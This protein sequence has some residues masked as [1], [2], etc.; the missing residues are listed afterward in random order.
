MNTTQ[1][2][3]LQTL[4]CV[5]SL[6][7]LSACGQAT[8]AAPTLTPIPSATQ[9]SAPTNT[10]TPTPPPTATNTPE[11]TPIPGVQVY[12]VSSL[13]KGIPWLPYDTDHKPMTVYY[14]FNVDKPPFDNVLVRQAFAAAIDREQ[15]AQQ[16]LG[17]NFRN[18]RPATSLTPPEVLAR[19]LYN[20]VGIQFNPTK[21][22]EYLQQAGYSSVDSFP[23][24]TL[25]VS[26]RGKGA[27][28]AYYQMAKTIVG[29]W[30]TNLGIKV[31]IEVVEIRSYRARFSTN[32]PAIYQLGWVADY[33]DP[34]N[35]LKALFH[36][37]SEIN[38]GHFSN[39]EFD[40]LVNRA[41]NFRD[42]ETRLSLYLEAEKILTE[43][44]TGVIPLY[45]CFVPI[46]YVY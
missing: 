1:N 34:D 33:Q 39:R 6:I 27:P 25:L 32:P 29:M 41:A 23:P 37:K 30:E 26:T 31:Q 9:T 7:L 16:A 12:P 13:D 22:K 24:T 42:P 3:R 2:R 45:H 18:A 21:A 38:Y 44:E 28:G 36:S 20:Q 4:F 11:P 35:F 8:V 15:I 40:R 46:P 10:A 19:D 14:G 5:L 43:I 17:Y